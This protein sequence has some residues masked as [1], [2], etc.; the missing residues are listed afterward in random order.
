MCPGRA[1][2]A[3]HAFRPSL[4]VVVR[5]NA[6]I[7]SYFGSCRALSDLKKTR[8]AYRPLSGVTRV[9]F[10]GS[11]GRGRHSCSR[12]SGGCCSHPGHCGCGVVVVVVP[13]L[14]LVVVVVVIGKDV[15]VIDD[16]L[17]LMDVV[18][19]VDND[20]TI[21]LENSCARRAGQRGPPNRT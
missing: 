17:V 11:R 4:P 1:T 18:V 7:V 8:H 12:S 5:Q 3:G 16:V 15:V 10:G 20:M 13:V 21:A 2:P 6:G 9:T 14:G 19:V